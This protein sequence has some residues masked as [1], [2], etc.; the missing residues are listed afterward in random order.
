M[1]TETQNA[2][3]TTEDRLLLWNAEGKHLAKPG[4]ID[5]LLSQA[6][7]DWD[8]E[9]TNLYT[10][11]SATDDF[12]E[13]ANKRA[14]RR[15]DTNHVLGVCGPRYTP[16]GNREI[17]EFLDKVQ[18]TGEALY[19]AGWSSRGG[20]VVGVTMRLAEE[21]QIAGFDSHEIYLLATTRHDGGGAIR[22]DATPVRLSCTNMVTI[23]QKSAQ[24]THR[25][26][27]SGS[28]SSK[29]ANAR[30]ALNLTYHY[31]EAW[32]NEVEKLIETSMSEE[33]IMHIAKNLYSEK[34][35]EAVLTHWGTSP[36]IAD[37]RNTAYG[38][39]NAITEWNQ[40]A[41]PRR[42]KKT[43]ETMLYGG[44]HRD[45]QRAFDLITA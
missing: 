38:A 15:T 25:I 42:V 33:K 31:T 14:I 18:D 10:Q 8:V 6:N 36:T 41:R 19:E 28:I 9:L 34:T 7:L 23:A 45:D 17:L 43:V 16:C 12:Q 37:F 29:I 2:H 13:V 26:V 27:H 20:A 1:T 35:A 24:R 5:E 30:E 44:I 21:V 4:S 32:S 22:I 11:N 3:R 39:L 40:W